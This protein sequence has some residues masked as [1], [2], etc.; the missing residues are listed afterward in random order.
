MID[1][2]NKTI[3]KND[4]VMFM[5]STSRWMKLLYLGKEKFYVLD[6]YN[7]L[8]NTEEDFVFSVM[9]TQDFKIIGNKKETPWLLFA[10][11]DKSRNDNIKYK[12]EI[13]DYGK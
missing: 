9:N 4:I 7:F 11:Y 12:I 2:R 3:K 10:E 6:S 8:K 1:S 13:I 5:G